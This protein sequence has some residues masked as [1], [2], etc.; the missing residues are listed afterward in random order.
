LLNE[1]F[2]RNPNQY[3]G[4][5]AG[6]WGIDGYARFYA[7]AISIFDSTNL[8]TASV[9]QFYFEPS[10]GKLWIGI[11][12]SYWNG[13]SLTTFSAASPSVSGLPTDQLYAFGI[14]GGN[15][16][17]WYMYFEEQDWT[18]SPPASGV[19][20]NSA[21]LGTPSFQG[22]DYFT[23]TLAQE[24]NIEADVASAVADWSSNVTLYKNLAAAESWIHRFSSDASNEYLTGDN[25]SPTYQSTSTLTGT[26]NWVAFSFRTENQAYQA[27]RN[28]AIR[29]AQSPR[30]RII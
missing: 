15:S 24:A 18:Y 19:P 22:A 5:T 20:I 16:G 17:G 14:R 23:V 29:M 6:S 8:T 13:S 30:S 4:S 9:V 3:L 11:D 1:S 28:L 7:E 2:D 12:D 27:D 21:N 10:E 25:A 26:N